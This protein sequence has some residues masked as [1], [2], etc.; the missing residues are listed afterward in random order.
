M[1]SNDRPMPSTLP[2]ARSA[3][4]TTRSTLSRTSLAF[5]AA[6]LPRAVACST[7][8]ASS[9]SRARLGVAYQFLDGRRGGPHTLAGSHEVGADILHVI[10]QFR[11]D[12]GPHLGCS[13]PQAP[14]DLVQVIDER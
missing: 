4:P 2:M 1:L 12:E 8:R 11:V 5:A 10:R 14:R 7:L 13:K 3:R 9:G 6:S